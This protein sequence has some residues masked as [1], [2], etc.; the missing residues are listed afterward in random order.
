MAQAL[1]SGNETAAAMKLR[2]EIGGAFIV[3]AL[4]VV[5]RTGLFSGVRELVY[6]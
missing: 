2:L 4:I 5:P 6:S 3:I 1:T